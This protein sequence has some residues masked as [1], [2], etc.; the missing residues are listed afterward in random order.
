L[1]SA[2]T[3]HCEVDRWHVLCCRRPE[4]IEIEIAAFLL[5][6][7]NEFNHFRFVFE[8][9]G[10]VKSVKPVIAVSRPPTNLWSV[11]EKCDSKKWSEESRADYVCWRYM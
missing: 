3:V 11:S 8:T 1:L 6:E 10:E 9:H 4:Q 5:R 7:C 2:I